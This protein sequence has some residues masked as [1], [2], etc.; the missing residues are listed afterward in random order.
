ML[1]GEQ[2]AVWTEHQANVTSDWLGKERGIQHNVNATSWFEG[3]VDNNQWLYASQWS[4]EMTWGR[5]ANP[6]MNWNADS[7]QD[8]ATFFQSNSSSL[9]S[10]LDSVN[11]VSMFIQQY[12]CVMKLGGVIFLQ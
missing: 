2:A 12:P 10:I 4:Q 5:E 8:D 7:S 1:C 3:Q 6:D 9:G 11:Q